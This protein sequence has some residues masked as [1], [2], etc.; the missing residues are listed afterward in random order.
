MHKISVYTKIFIYLL[1]MKSSIHPSIHPFLYVLL[2][3]N[4]FTHSSV[5]VFTTPSSVS[6]FVLFL[7]LSICLSVLSVFPTLLTCGDTTE[8]SPCRLRSTDNVRLLPIPIGVPTLN[9]SIFGCIIR[10]VPSKRATLVITKIYMC[11]R[12]PGVPQEIYKYWC[13]HHW[14]LIP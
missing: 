12:N 5:S 4:S 1:S 8:G 13:E 14:H 10:L 7:L 6:V 3:S 11:V 9:S 2:L